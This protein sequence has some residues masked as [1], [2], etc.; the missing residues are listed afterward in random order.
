MNYDTNKYIDVIQFYD[1]MLII[2]KCRVYAKGA[3]VSISGDN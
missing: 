2:M 3:N 1:L